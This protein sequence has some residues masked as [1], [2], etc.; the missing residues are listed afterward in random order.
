MPSSFLQMWQPSTARSVSLDGLM[1]LPRGVPPSDLSPLVWPAKDPGDV[2]DYEFDITAALAGDPTDQVSSVTVSVQPYSGAADLTVGQTVALGA[3][4]VIWLSSGQVGT[5]YAVSVSV[6]TLK[7]RVIGR[8]ILLPVQQ[9]NAIAPPLVPLTTDGGA[10]ITDQ[11]NNP[12]L[13]S[14]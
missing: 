7:G 14:T 9:L 11:N 8:T 12:I 6:G 5:T 3:V 2:L 1:P 4:A 13:V 10:T